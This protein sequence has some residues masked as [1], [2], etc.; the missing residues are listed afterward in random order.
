MGDTAKSK[1]SKKSAAATAGKAA[2]KKRNDKA[3]ASTPAAIIAAARARAFTDDAPATAF[4]H[5]RPMAEKIATADLAVFTGQPLLL[6]ANI[7]T[8][9]EA[10]EPHLD[11]AVRALREPRLELVFELPALVMALSFGVGRVPIAKLSAGEIEKMLAEGAPFRELMLS[12]LE[13]AAHP[14]LNLLPRERVAAVRAGTGKLDKAEDFVAIPGL[15]AEFESALAGKHPFPAATI[16]L[17][18]TLGG[19]LVK[20]LRPGNAIAEVA[21]RTKESILRD[22][23]ASMVVDRYDHLQVLTTIA[24]GK[25]K[26]D[27]LLPALRSSVGFGRPASVSAAVPVENG[28]AVTPATPLE[29]K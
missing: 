6:R 14:L 10:I 4:A 8:A 5:F 7:L 26:A 17:L 9:L 12:F 3:D 16:D 23:L 19:T 15:L 11:A 25:R 1:K 21:K 29:G 27:A 2:S 18:A 24:L 20:Q 28:A 22:Q 13:I